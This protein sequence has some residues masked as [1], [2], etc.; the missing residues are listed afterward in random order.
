MTKYDIFCKVVETGSFTRTGEQLGYS[1]SA[2]S[3]T[4]HGLEQELGTTLF[5]R[6]KNGVELTADGSQYLPYIRAI[7]GAEGALA[8]KRREMLG[9]ENSTIRIGTFTSVSRT[10]LPRLM[11]KFKSVYP[12][13]RFLLQQ[14]EY[15]TICQW[16]QEGSVDFGFVNPAAVQGLEVHPLYRD[17]MAAVLPPQHPLAARDGVSLRDLAAEPFILLDEGAYSVPMEA[18]RQM[19]LR[20]RIEYTVF[21]DYSILSMVSQGL[22]VAALYPIVLPGYGRDVVTLPIEEALERTVAIA[23]QNWET[24]PLAARSFTD[25]IRREAPRLLDGIPGVQPGI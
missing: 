13:V 19:G 9:L 21:D 4:V 11:Q 24:L 10:L 16:I 6:G 15:T 23:W 18:F 7:C 25:F 22:G 1:Q 2:V 3:Q 17:R 5:S 12:G 14:G 20:P 8:K